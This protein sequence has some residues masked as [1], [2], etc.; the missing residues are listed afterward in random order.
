MRKKDRPNIIITT[1]NSISKTCQA[2]KHNYVTFEGEKINP[3]CRAVKD[4]TITL[5]KNGNISKKTSNYNSIRRKKT[6][7]LSTSDIRDSKT[8]KEKQKLYKENGGGKTLQAAHIISLELGFY[9]FSKKP[10]LPLSVEKLK[11][12]L[13]ELNQQLVFETSKQNQS[14]D[15]KNDSFVKKIL[16][17]QETE[18]TPGLVNHVKRMLKAFKNI[19]KMNPTLTFIQENIKIVY[20]N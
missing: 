5:K 10:G 20:Q 8:Q 15:V 18:V 9:I 12:T 17:G 11:E 7:E 1:K 14:R 2:A 4:T 6:S 19:K 16:D 3:N 13:S